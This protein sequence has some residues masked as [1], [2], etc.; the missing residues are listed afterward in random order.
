[1]EGKAVKNLYLFVGWLGSLFLFGLY[2]SGSLLG[3]DMRESILKGVYP[4]IVVSILFVFVK[5][6]REV[7]IIVLM[8]PY[9]LFFS[10]SFLSFLNIAEPLTGAYVVNSSVFLYGL[11]FY[12]VS[13]AYMLRKGNV[14]FSSWSM[15]ANPLLVV[16][17][18]VLVVDNFYLHANFRR[19]IRYFGPFVV[20]GIFLYLIISLP[21][22]GFMPLRVKTDLVSS[23]VFALIFE[24]FVYSNFAGISLLFYGLFGIMGIRIPLNFRQPFSATSLIEFWRG[25]HI[26]LSTVMK[27]FFYTP[28]RSQHNSG[29]AIIVVFVSSGLWHGISLN[30]IIWGVFHAAFFILTLWLVK[31]AWTFAACLLFPFGVII[32]RLI[33]AESKTSVLLEKLQFNYD[34][35]AVFG[36]VLNFT[37]SSLFALFLGLSFVAAEFVMR[38]TRYFIKRNYK[39]YRLPVVQL[40]LVAITLLSLN[41]D[42]FLGYAA[43][44]QR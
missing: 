19:R 43:Y 18:P 11:S 31:R 15:A 25:W 37:S 3:G 13:L 40:V 10:I 36:E 22:I 20:L 29:L 4:L 30:F 17:G 5:S 41:D 16:T 42:I 7:K 14:S 44:G 34:S 39:F 28:V 21:L 27:V 38:N 24:V 1:M 2:A 9:A 35:F 8:L 23:V 6:I 26:S 32:G 12:S 33:F